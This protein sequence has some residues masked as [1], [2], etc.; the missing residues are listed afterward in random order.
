[1]GGICRKLL[2]APEQPVDGVADPGALRFSEKSLY[3]IHGAHKRFETV[4]LLG[5][6]VDQKFQD[7]VADALDS[8]GIYPIASRNLPCIQRGGLSQ[9]G[10]LPG[11]TGRVDVGEV[12]RSSVKR[13]VLRK[14]RLHRNRETSE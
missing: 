1:M 7:N 3:P 2:E 4:L 11:V 9:N 8:L 10:K 12:I 13:A 14:K 5:F 6:C